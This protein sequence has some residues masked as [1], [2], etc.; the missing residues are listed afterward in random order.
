MRTAFVKLLLTI[1]VSAMVALAA[2]GVYIV[3]LQ[4][5][6]NPIVAPVNNSIQHL[7]NQAPPPAQQR[8][9]AK[10]WIDPGNYNPDSPSPK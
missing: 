3:A 4:S 1:T 7:P 9:P 10:R 2:M 8:M 6:D 5:Q